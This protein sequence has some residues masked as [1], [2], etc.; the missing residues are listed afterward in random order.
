V[1][2]ERRQEFQRRRDYIVP[3][4][5]RLGFT[6]PV[7][8]DGAYY[9]YADCSRFSDDADALCRDILDRTG[10][11]LTPGLDFGPCGA[12]RF[13]RVSYATAMANLEEAMRR[14][15]DYLSAR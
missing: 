5:L 15:R 10:V 3:E 13:I 12:K 14:L 2:E 8:P 6:I 4:L 11:V 9:V 7:L 1:A